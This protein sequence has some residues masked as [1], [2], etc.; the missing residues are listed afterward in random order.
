[1]PRGLY[2]LDVEIGTNAQSLRSVLYPTHG[3]ST[4]WI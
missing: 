4:D 3:L 2:I 1:M